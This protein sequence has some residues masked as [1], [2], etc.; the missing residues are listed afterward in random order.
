MEDVRIK[1]ERFKVLAE[2]L[3]KNNKQVFIKD[4]DDNLYFGD[5]IF[6]GEDLI[7]INCFSPIHRRGQKFCIYWPLIQQLEEYK[8][9]IEA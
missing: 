7:E 5:I 6:V 2:I 3:L 9:R 8:E 4:I 1:G